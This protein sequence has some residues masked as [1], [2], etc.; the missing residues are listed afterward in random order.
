M[1]ERAQELNGQLK[2]H[3]APDQGTEISL[4]IPLAGE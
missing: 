1:K 3:S 4:S 2:V